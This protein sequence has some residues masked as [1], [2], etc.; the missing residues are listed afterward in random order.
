MAMVIF[1]S[2]RNAEN[3]FHIGGTIQMGEFKNVQNVEQRRNN[4]RKAKDAC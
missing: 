4:D 3:A 2:V 1:G